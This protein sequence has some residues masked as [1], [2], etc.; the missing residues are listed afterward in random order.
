MKYLNL[1]CGQRFHP[2]WTNINF[3]STGDGVIAHN[4]K[5]GIP[6][7]DDSFNV[8]YHSHILEHFPKTEAEP[9]IKECYRVLR[10]QGI[11]RVVVPDLEQIAKM[12]LYCLEQVSTGSQKWDQNYQWM[13]LEMYDQTVRT[14]PGGEMINF[15]SRQSL[16]NQEFVVKRCGVEI[17]NII[18]AAQKQYS[19]L[20]PTHENE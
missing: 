7:P 3:A 11:L 4:L 12:Y 17:Q 5:H 14:Q 10:P 8:V 13:L 6:F 19:A 18:L 1:G 2:S 9:F 16:T 15:L 20:K